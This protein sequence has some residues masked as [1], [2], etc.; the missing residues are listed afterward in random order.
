MSRRA[1]PEVIIAR[2]IDDALATVTAAR[3]APCIHTADTAAAPCPR[4]SRRRSDERRADGDAAGA[5]ADDAGS[6]EV[7]ADGGVRRDA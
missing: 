3:V 7:R 2:R 4:R 6:A 1:S 5:E